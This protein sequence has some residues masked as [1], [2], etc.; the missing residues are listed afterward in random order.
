MIPRR[1][2]GYGE[3]DGSGDEIREAR[4]IAEGG[5]MR[6]ISIVVLM[7]GALLLGSSSCATVPTK[8][9]GP[10]ELK[11]LSMVVPEK[12]NIKVNLPFVV[13]IRF[14]ADGQPEIRSACF[15]IA[16][17]GPHCFKVTDVNYGSPGTIRAQIHTKNPGSRLLEVYVLYIRDGKIQPTNVVSTYFRPIP[18]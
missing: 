12:E 16:G 15:S 18:Q 9:L 13:D 14:E 4:G 7:M 10:G 1:V 3:G 6:P 8:P 17:D 5:F 11:L 2:L